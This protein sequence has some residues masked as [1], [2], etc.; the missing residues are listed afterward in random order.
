DLV[1][2]SLGALNEDLAG[3]VDGKITL[4]GRGQRLAGAVD[5]SLKGARARGAG[6]AVSVDGRVRAVLDDQTLKIDA[7]ATNAGGLRSVASVTLPA[8]AS[9]APLR[10]AI[11]TRE[12]MSGRFEA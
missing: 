8:A 7:V 1:N 10:L 3:T 4:Q 9:A 12:P 11:A 5:A 2:V 6:R